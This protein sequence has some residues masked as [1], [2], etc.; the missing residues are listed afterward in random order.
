MIAIALTVNGDD[1]RE[2][3]EPRLSLADFLRQRL[4]LTGTR[5]GCEMGACGACL[6]R[7]DGRVVHACLLLAAQADGATVETIEH[8]SETG[9]LRDLQDAFHARN[10]LQCG[11]CTAG[12]LMTAHEYL[13]NGGGPDRA[14]IRDALSGNYCRCTGYQAIVDAIQTVLEARRETG[15]KA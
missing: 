2:T 6:V 12:V 8:L 15:A 7:L 11:Y 4:G 10:A 3:V 1:V 14:A 13:E 5:V 9:A